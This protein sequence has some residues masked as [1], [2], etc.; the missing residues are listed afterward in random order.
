MEEPT[1]SEPESNYEKKLD[2]AD[3]VLTKLK[4]LLIKHWGILMIILLSYGIYWF[5]GEVVKEMDKPDQAQDEYYDE[6]P[7]DEEYYP[8]QSK[9]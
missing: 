7:Y 1:K 4:K 6:D 3:G 8:E 9:D 5:W 2:V